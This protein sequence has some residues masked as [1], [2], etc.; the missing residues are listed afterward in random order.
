MYTIFE[1]SHGHG[2]GHGLESFL[3]R[4]EDIAIE[5]YRTG[6]AKAFAFIFYD[7]KDSDFKR[8]MKDQGVFANLDRL[9]G[10]ELSIFYLHSGSN[11]SIER[12]NNTLLQALGVKSE[13]NPPCVVFCKISDDGFKDVS[14]ALLESADIMHGFHELYVVI[15]AYIKGNQR[16][17][18]SKYL[19]WI[20]G[21]L[22]FVSLESIKALVRESLKGPF[23]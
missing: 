16:E 15:D 2:I 10:D 4:F 14:V 17:V 20:K 23:W 8:I 6:R 1:Q 12:F 9:S 22:K 7:F 18:E 21:P 3:D 13:A 5:H 19:R 11:H